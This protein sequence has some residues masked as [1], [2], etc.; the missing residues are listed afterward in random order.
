MTNSA[1][2]AVGVSAMDGQTSVSDFIVYVMTSD[3]YLPA[4]RP[5]AWLFNKYWGAEQRVQV[6]GFAQPDFELPSNF[7]FR[8]LGPQ[9]N[10]PWQRWSNALLDTMADMSEDEIFCLMLEDYWISRRV[11]VEA[12]CLLYQHMQEDSSILKVDL[13]ADRLY[14]LGMTEYG[15]LDR[16]DL[17]RSHHDS[18]YHMSLMTGLW[19]RGL[20]ERIII[21][22]ESPHDVEIH[23][24]TRLARLK[25]DVKVLGT[26][27][28]PVRHILAHRGGDPGVTMVGGLCEDDINELT[29]LGYIRR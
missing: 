19:R 15:A 20:M 11:D 28:W 21:P 29:T 8:S 3:K 2:R 12:V 1:R 10:Y 16:L 9:R 7:S 27:Q 14:A 6:V 18:P 25:D 23:G 22:E 13:C 5:F 24:T 17:V 4:L 26:R